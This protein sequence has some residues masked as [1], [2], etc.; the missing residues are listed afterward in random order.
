MPIAFD[1]SIVT[2]QR[3]VKIICGL[4]RV[5][6]INLV[7]LFPIPLFGDTGRSL[8]VVSSPGALEGEE[9]CREDSSRIR[10]ALWRSYLVNRTTFLLVLLW[11]DRRFL[12]IRPSASSSN[13]RR[14]CEITLLSLLPTSVTDAV[15]KLTYNARTVGR[16][17]HEPGRNA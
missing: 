9:P 14:L 13:S 8:T 2:S 16:M 4:P 7:P 1:P 5:E 3:K 10:S 15:V 17:R 11:T 12:A 6:L